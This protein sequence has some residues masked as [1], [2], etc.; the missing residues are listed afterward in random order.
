MAALC[1]LTPL[2]TL[3]TRISAAWRPQPRLSTPEWCTAHVRLP[4]EF[5]IP[6]RYDLDDFP[7]WREPLEALDDPEVFEISVMAATQIGKT[8]WL[9]AALCSQTDVDPAPMMLVGPDKDYVKELRDKLYAAA[10][11]NPQL[12]DRVPP[13]SLRNLQWLDL[14][15]CYVYL[16]W[17]RNTQRV[18]G[19]ACRRVFCSE[20]DRY[21]QPVREGS[22][23]DVVGERVKSFPRYQIIRESTPTDEHSAVAH[24]YGQSDERRFHVPCPHCGH[25]QELRFFVHT[26]GEYKGKGG[27]AGL[28]DDRGNWVLPDTALETAYYVC[29]HGCRIISAE[30]P[31]MVERGVWVPKGQRA[32][33][34]GGSVRLEGTPLRAGRH[35][36]Y[37]LS[38]LYA[39][40]ITFGRMASEYLKSRENH[41]KLQNW[42]NNWLGLRYTARAKVPMWRTLG[43]R[44]AGGHARGHVPPGA[45]F[46]TCGV[47]VQGDRV[48]WAVRAWGDGATS[49][50]VDWG[51]EMARVG[52]DGQYE[53]NSDLKALDSLVIARKFP[54]TTTGPLGVSHAQVLL[55]GADTGYEPARVWD[56]VRKQPAAR[57]RAIAGDTGMDNPFF[58]MTVVERNKR[59]G[60]PYPGGMKR[61]GINV[62]TYKADLHQRWNQ[63]L[64]EHGAWFVTDKCIDQGET[65]LRQLV[66]E[67][68]L[69]KEL[70]TGRTV[71]QWTVIDSAVG[72]HYWDCEVYARALADMVT[73]GDWTEKASWRRQLLAKPKAT[74]RPS[75]QDV[76]FPTPDGRN[77]LVTDR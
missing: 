49:W 40:V 15:K 32:V 74:Q 64:D 38:S 16:A 76:P 5:G 9:K 72:N 52:D 28:Q 57:V 44:N 20:I 55:T 29:E 11:I 34:A 51:M 25:Y 31:D 37:Q 48:Y 50:L 60:K 8:E 33:A 67:G 17:V 26:E 70:A 30:K 66:N 10:E 62:D 65:Y 12:R 7:Y 53:R 4:A 43:R 27:V 58:Q 19:K 23:H 3:A 59:T 21:G 1:S 63:P 68:P 54:F 39:R 46:L 71:P 61:W 47:D 69:P 45:L 73:G 13:I 42:W 41:R 6:G 36:G 35:R 56:W 14:A 2:G 22:I 18:S 77:F 24:F 75:E